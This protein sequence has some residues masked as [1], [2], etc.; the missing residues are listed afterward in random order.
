MKTISCLSRVPIL[1][2][3]LLLVGVPAR[4]QSTFSNIYS[5]D[6]NASPA[7]FSPGGTLAAGPILSTGP[8]SFIFYGFAYNLASPPGGGIF[9]FY[10]DPASFTPLQSFPELTDPAQLNPSTIISFPY[11]FG[12]QPGVGSMVLS[13]D[14]SEVYGIYPTDDNGDGSVFQMDSD[15]NNYTNIFTFLSYID[16][17]V[18]SG[19]L[20]LSPDGSALYG[21]AQRGG[22]NGTGLVFKVST[23]DGS[24][25]DL[26]SFPTN[27]PTP[28]LGDYP[29]GVTLTSDGAVLYGTAIGGPYVNP[30]G[31]LYALS[32]T[33]TIP[34]HIIHNF[35]SI[36]GDGL[37]P[38]GNVL[39]ANGM[40]YGA[41]GGGG[42]DNPQTPNIQHGD[43]V[44]FAVATNGNG[45]TILH[46][47]LPQDG[48]AVVGPL[49][50]YNQ[51]LYGV[52]TVGGSNNTG[53]IFEVNIDGTGFSVIH[54]FSALDTNGQNSDGAY[55]CSAL[56][57]GRLSLFGT[58]LAG[59]PKGGG[60]VF[61][62]RPAP[63]VT[64]S[65]VP[66]DQVIQ[67]SWGDGVQKFTVQT[68]TADIQGVFL[69]P[70][71]ILIVTNPSGTKYASF[72]AASGGF[73]RLVT[74]PGPPTVTTTGYA[75]LTTNS[76]IANGTVFA[77]GADTTVWF[78]Y[79]PS[80]NYGV[81]SATTLVVASNT[82]IVPVSTPLTAGLQAG[83]TYYF[84]LVGTNIYGTNYGGQLTFTT[85]IPP[86]VTTLPPTS[87]GATV[88]T[89]NGSINGEDEAVAAYFQYDLGPG[90]PGSTYTYNTR[91]HQYLGAPGGPAQNFSTTITGLNPGMQYHYQAVGFN[92]SSY[93]GFG[94][95]TN[96]TTAAL[97]S[98]PTIVSPGTNSSFGPYPY[99]T[100]LTPTFTWNNNGAAS[101]ALSYAEYPS[102]AGSGTVSNLSGSPAAPVTLQPGTNYVWNLTASDSYG[103]QS[104]GS[105]VLYF[106]TPGPP[107]TTMDVA[108]NTGPNAVT[109]Y[110]SVNPNGLPASVQFQF[111]KGTGTNYGNVVPATPANIGTAVQI[112]SQNASVATGTLYHVRIYASNSMG[113]TY[114]APIQFT[115]E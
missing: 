73:F 107:I 47:F 10:T 100:T 71:N 48:G 12:L 27:N 115:S 78:E 57:G 46:S 97:P 96:F 23:A 18:P 54:T 19:N 16:G 31:V 6:T 109:F 44:I 72:P 75:S 29:F 20:A 113:I 53:T 43:G 22:T 30:Y 34:P 81:N 13:S 14:G 7:V 25:T 5:F 82:A 90:G 114:S 33:G 67:I 95:D 87:V 37:Y 108:S 3:S 1:F 8:D 70:T 91:N 26:Y 11:G 101:Y 4:G 61:Q 55:P 63:V 17:Y 15:G 49:L 36:N 32:T 58:T 83:V 35:G 52:C 92:G 66:E 28:P 105:Q 89:L 45:Y 106:S 60:T 21:T 65:N 103:D 93:E 84:Q 76:A 99:V 111:D 41:T 42:I 62:F 38:V 77:N 50:Q 2:A 112:Y 39:L 110:G 79:G 59:G 56:V 68:K 104:A 69:T 102:G 51:T 85:P 64:I 88:A 80:T 40:L 9:E 98:T 74:A 86:V 24:F 94:A